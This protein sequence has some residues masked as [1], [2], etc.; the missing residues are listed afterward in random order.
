MSGPFEI[1]RTEAAYWW[2]TNVIAGVILHRLMWLFIAASAALVW[3]GYLV[4]GFVVV[5]GMIPYGF[6]L[7]YLAE[8]ACSNFLEEHPEAIEKFIESRV[9]TPSGTDYSIPEP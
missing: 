5:L 1:D 3:Q 2:R 9:I 7:R 4:L 8:R 6:F